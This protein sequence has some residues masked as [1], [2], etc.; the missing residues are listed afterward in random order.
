[1]N[2]ELKCVKL[3]KKVYAL[4]SKGIDPSTP[5]FLWHPTEDPKHPFDITIRLFNDFSGSHR[6]H[7]TESSRSS[8]P[9]N[10]WVDSFTPILMMTEI[11]DCF[12]GAV[13]ALSQQTTRR[14]MCK[15]LSF[16]IVAAILGASIIDIPSY[17]STARLV[18]LLFSRI[19]PFFMVYY[20]TGC[21]QPGDLSAVE[22]SHKWLQTLRYNVCTHELKDHYL[23]PRILHLGDAHH[24][25]QRAF[26]T[27]HEDLGLKNPCYS[28]STALSYSSSIPK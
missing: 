1:M 3:E 21:N 5:Q 15:T 11:H 4:P 9:Y 25:I 18:L 26:F 10:R 16:P 19:S 17:Y 27:A 24:P 8:P 7:L 2:K 6:K 14:E 23:T 20:L 22:Y 13:T 28:E 12:I